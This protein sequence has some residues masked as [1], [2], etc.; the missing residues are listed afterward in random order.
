MCL[1]RQVVKDVD[2]E[3]SATTGAARNSSLQEALT[4]HA[5]W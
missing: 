4:W 2:E 5:A 1:W 3:T